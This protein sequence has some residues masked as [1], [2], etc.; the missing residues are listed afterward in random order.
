[1]AITH[2]QIQAQ[3]AFDA[4]RDAQAQLD[5][6]K[7]SKNRAKREK[8]K[9]AQQRAKEASSSTQTL[10]AEPEAAD[11]LP[12]KRRVVAGASSDAPASAPADA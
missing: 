6:A 3:A 9:R 1:M 12:R 11:D 8:K 7:T 5:E 10:N 2:A 4:K